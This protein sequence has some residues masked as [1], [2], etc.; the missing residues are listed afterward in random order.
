MLTDRNEIVAI[1]EPRILHLAK[2]AGKETDI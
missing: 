2:F 1:K